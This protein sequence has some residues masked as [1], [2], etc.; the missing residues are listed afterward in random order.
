MQNPPFTVGYIDATCPICKGARRS[1]VIG[2]FDVTVS[3]LLPC[4]DCGEGEKFA[5]ANRQ[6]AYI[7]LARRMDE[8]LADHDPRRLVAP[9]P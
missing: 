2:F 1:H 8:A 9:E 3:Y 4:R 5:A 7:E 6:G